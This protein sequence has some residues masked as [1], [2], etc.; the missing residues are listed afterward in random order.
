MQEEIA[1]RKGFMP[2]IMRGKQLKG[3]CYVSPEGF[4]SK[5]DFE[6]WLKCCLD[7]NPKAK[8]SKK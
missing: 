1:S 7:F 5:R 8:A 3:Y 6:F 2:M 4:K